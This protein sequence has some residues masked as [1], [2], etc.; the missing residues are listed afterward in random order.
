MADKQRIVVKVGTSTLTHPTGRTNFRR[1]EALVRVLSDLQNQGLAMTLVTSGAIGV[2]VGKLGL[3]G[4]PSDTP[5]KQAAATVGQ[6]E[7]MYMYDKFF[8]EYGQKVG[9]LLITRGDMED[10]ARHRNLLAAFDRLFDWGVIPIIN[11][12]DAV[13]VEEIVY[14]DNDALSAHVAVLVSA[15]KLIILTDIDGLYDKNPAL[16]PDARLIERVET[17]TPEIHALARGAGSAMGTG[18]METKLKAAQLACQEGIDTHIING[19]TP[20]NI[21]RLLAGE[22]VGSWFKAGKVCSEI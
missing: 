17:I 8:A 22:Q 12:N 9:Q 20:E 7:L 11:E 5:G 21:H 10:P 4:R 16:H 13:A 18:G 14:G 15:E 3:D 2:G 19:N 6:C 1:V